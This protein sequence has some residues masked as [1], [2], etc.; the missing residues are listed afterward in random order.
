MCGLKNT[1]GVAVMVPLALVL[2]LEL[3][4]CAGASNAV[5][6]GEGSAGSGG[7]VSVG[8]DTEKVQGTGGTGGDLGLG[9]M[10]GEGGIAACVATSAEATLQMKPVDIVF[11]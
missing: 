7:S 8:N 2:G 1:V 3:G 11:I 4:G 10:Q 9:G 5:E 6:P